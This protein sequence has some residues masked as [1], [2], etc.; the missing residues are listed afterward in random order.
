MDIVDPWQAMCGSSI[1]TKR[2]KFDVILLGGKD[3]PYQLVIFCCDDVSN[4]KLPGSLKLRYRSKD[5]ALNEAH[6]IMRLFDMGAVK[7]DPWPR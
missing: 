7:G 2:F 1:G 6:N 4:E 3:D 5:D